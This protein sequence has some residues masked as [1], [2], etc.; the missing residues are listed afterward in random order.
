MQTSLIKD[1]YNKAAESYSQNRDQFSNTRYLDLLLEHLDH[2]SL[3]LDVGCGAGDPIDSYLIARGHRIIGLDLSEKQIELA[4][5]NVPNGTYF[6]R[7]MTEITANEFSVD[8]IVSFYAIFHIPREAHL[9]LFQKLNSYLSP[10]GYMLI[11]MGSSPW[12]GVENFHGVQMFWSHY[13]PEKN[14]EMIEQAGFE[15]E[16]EEID[17]SYN[18]KH[19]IILAKKK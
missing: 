9:A 14:I 1:G 4:K 17:H 16:L 8:A 12:E 7:D 6:V 19:Q 13:G 5:K 2:N 11:T 18:E 15:I 10:G 3:V